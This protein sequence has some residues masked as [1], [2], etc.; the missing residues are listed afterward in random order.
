MKKGLVFLVDTIIDQINSY[1]S[2]EKI[3]SFWKFAD[4]GVMIFQFG[5]GIVSLDCAAS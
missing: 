3:E 5:A 2:F 1:N 4:F